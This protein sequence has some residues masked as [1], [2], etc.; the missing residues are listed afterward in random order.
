MSKHIGLN[1]NEVVSVVEENDVHL[2]FRKI[3]WLCL[4]SFAIWLPII[5]LLSFYRYRL[6]IQLDNATTTFYEQW[7]F[8]WPWYISWVWFTPLLVIVVGLFSQ[9]KNSLWA[10]ITKHSLLL[11]VFFV[12]YSLSVGFVAF[13]VN[14]NLAEV[15][16]FWPGLFKMIQHNSWPYDLTIYVAV[17]LAA[18]VS[19]YLEK[20]RIKDKENALLQS[21]LYKAQLD[22]L[23]S[24]L[25][26][27]FLFNALNTISGLMRL[28]SSN[29]ATLALSELSFMLRTMLERQDN[30]V[31][32]QEEI[33][34]VEKYIYFQTLRFED[35]LASS[36]EIE[37][38]AKAIKL[39]FL[40]IHTLVENA[41]KHGAQEDGL[42][43]F[44]AISASIKDHRL[45]IT[46][47]NKMSQSHQYESF[48]IGL[49]NCEQRLSLSYND[50]FVLRCNEE[51]NKEYLTSII[52]PLELADV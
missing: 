44:I 39:P 35:S 45:H 38:Q 1:N 29:N 24:Q 43:N 28:G 52:V 2:N 23:K 30:T 46:L 42:Q 47:R 48:G 36:I 33:T 3:A 4:V 6:I 34:F 50:D 21:Q 49:L 31:S 40:L 7:Y 18:Y 27:H 22:A 9:H 32:L 13:S 16:E 10:L 8:I 17:L 19:V 25:N 15:D 41:I 20:L 12:S 14:G 11:M 51:S 26:P 37:Q 5:A